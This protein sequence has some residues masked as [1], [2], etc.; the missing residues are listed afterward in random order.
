MASK[1]LQK[2]I[3]T[4]RSRPAPGNI[5]IKE[6]RAAMEAESTRIRLA[7]DVRCQPVDAGGVPA[8]WVATSESVEEQVIHYLH[9]GGYVFGSISAH[10]EMASRLSR[11]AKA[12]VLLIGYRLAPE[13][14]FPAAV[15]DSLAGYRWLLS[16]GVNP[17]QVVIGGDSAGGGLAVATLV[18]LRD[19]GE[20][21]PAAA[22]AVSPW[23]DMECLGESMVTKAKIDPFIQRDRLLALTRS[24]LG[25]AD[26]RT[27][28]AS[29]IYADLTGLPPL[30]IQVGTSE[31]LFDDAKRL[32]ERAEAA[33]VKVVL[34]P[35][36]D[37][38]HTWHSFAAMLLE[39]QQ[40]IG[41]IGEFVQEHTG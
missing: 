10:R 2:I 6:Q 31:V 14:P 7:P 25:D 29:P 19:A 8:E 11:A 38:I 37:M 15:E 1:E 27:P 9:G 30:L 3:N 41:R 20:P 39:G 35:W 36:E 40:A 16:Q 4:L 13:N 17:A 28:L 18:A 32:A 24:Y 34:E 21:L 12:R 22:V 23:V 26:P 33:G 5:S